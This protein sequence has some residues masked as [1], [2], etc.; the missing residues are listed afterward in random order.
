MHLI[1]TLGGEGEGT[2][3]ESRLIPQYPLS[4]AGL[5]DFSLSVESL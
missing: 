2:S 3:K 4:R 5:L 1:Q